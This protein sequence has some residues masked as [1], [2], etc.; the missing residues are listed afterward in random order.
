MPQYLIIPLAFLLGFSLSRVATCTV[1]AT[2]RWVNQ[3]RL[4]WMGGLLVVMSWS[5]LVLFFLLL[6]S[7]RAH[8]PVDIEIRSSLFVGAIF[9]GLGALINRGCFIGTIGYIGTGQFSYLLS[10]VG[11]GL[12]MWLAGDNM[13][14]LFD[15]VT[16]KKRTLIPDDPIKQG[17]VVGFVI[18][19]LIS[20]WLL[21]MKRNF[22]MLALLTVG[23]SAALM[24][25]T[26]PEW[27]YA[28]VL[29]SLISGQGLSVGMTVEIAVITL[30]IGAI[31]SSWLKDRFKPTFGTW[32]L[33]AGN[34]AG[35]FLMGIGASAVP[36]GNDILL[37]WTIPGLALYGAIAYL[38]MIATIALA[39]KL[40][41]IIQSKLGM[42]SQP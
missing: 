20:L 28:A 42:A 31:V 12:A 19:C 2:D 24:F 17:V 21:V 27:A 8:I 22:A 9:M 32:K 23:V 37:M 18:I 36:G 10:F 13:L 38:V 39:L 3:G 6:Y 35:G 29:N 26:R 4:D 14:D 30:F 7:G 16:A 1:A 33:A 15:P 11:L 40:M 25:G 34:L 41:P 5:G